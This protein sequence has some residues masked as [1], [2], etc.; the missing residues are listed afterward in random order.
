[1]SSVIVTTEDALKKAQ[2][3]KVEEIIIVGELAE[4]I[5]KSKKIATLGAVGIAAIAALIPVGAS[6]GGVAYL[7]AV[8]VAMATGVSIPIII[9]AVLF[10][11]FL[12][13]QL[14]KEYD[15]VDFE[16]GEKGAKL[17]LRRKQD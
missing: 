7:A 4:K 14:F 8:P 6:T 3:D 10:G 13:I 17:K 12:L 16:I 2:Q 9:F 5:H 11:L 1:M 15:E